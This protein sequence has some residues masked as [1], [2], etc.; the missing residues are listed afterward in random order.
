MSRFRL[1]RR[2]LTGTFDPGYS[3]R[4]WEVQARVLVFP[5]GEG[6][7]DDY[8]AGFGEWGA[9]SST[10]FKNGAKPMTA[11]SVTM[12]QTGDVVTIHFE[13][14][15]A[16]FESPDAADRSSGNFPI[17]EYNLSGNRLTQFRGFPEHNAGATLVRGLTSIWKTAAGNFNRY[18]EAN[19]APFSQAHDIDI[20]G[21]HIPTDRAPNFQVGKLAAGYTV[22]ARILRKETGRTT[23]QGSDVTYTV[24]D[25][26]LRPALTP[27]PVTFGSETI[28]GRDVTF[29]W[30]ASTGASGYEVRLLE[31][32]Y[33]GNSIVET[34][35]QT[36]TGLSWTKVGGINEHFTVQVR[37]FAGGG[38]GRRNS[39]WA[40]KV[41]APTEEVGKI[42]NLRASVG[43]ANNV[44]LILTWKAI[45]GGV[46]YE[47]QFSDDGGSSWE[48][49]HIIPASADGS[50]I[51]HT[52]TNY[53]HAETLLRLRA[54]KEAEG[55]KTYSLSYTI[56]KWTPTPEGHSGLAP[57]HEIV[58]GARNGNVILDWSEPYP[59]ESPVPTRY[60]IQR[61]GSAEGATW[62]DVA[63][64]TVATQYLD[65]GASSGSN[66]FYRIRP[67]EALQ[68][69]QGPWCEIAYTQ[70]ERGAIIAPTLTATA[71]DKS[72]TGNWNTVANAQT[73]ELHYRQGTSGELDD[74][75]FGYRRQ[76]AHD[77][78]ADSF[79]AISNARTRA[80]GRRVVGL[81]GRSFGHYSRG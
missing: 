54:Y 44:N 79:D 69:S 76:Y 11:P 32:A 50:S 28:S 80:R 30:Q 6:S 65:T 64:V 39:A 59:G 19:N 15:T 8:D 67:E 48:D 66:W 40:D 20:T 21:W 42:T 58:A 56:F 43:G 4:Y 77:H 37:A 3:A 38:V 51:E 71:Q 23:V 24:V 45:P 14:D 60:K 13:P 34:I 72:I 70:E 68:A 12:T 9:A 81:V 26:A 63:T 53:A 62:A 73:Y 78:G 29:H 46:K 36:G 17:V 2:Q 47:R 22:K 61:K 49:P 1:T 31:D 25:P 55:A 75:R 5:P 16:D 10:A 41:Y 35:V 57:I 52:M 33:G 18:K 27:P 7:L 74:G